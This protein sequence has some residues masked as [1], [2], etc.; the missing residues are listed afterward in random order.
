MG[1]LCR[2]VA[3][4]LPSRP[5]FLER[6]QATDQQVGVVDF[7]HLPDSWDDDAAEFRIKERKGG[8]AVEQ[9]RLSDYIQGRAF[10][11]WC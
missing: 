6:G 11:G 1:D 2:E 8:G 9:G 4:I 5:S 3:L 7:P 10:S